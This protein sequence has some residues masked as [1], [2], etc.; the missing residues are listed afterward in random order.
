V[1]WWTPDT[2][3]N[4]IF[5]TPRQIRAQIEACRR[6]L[7]DAVGEHSNLFRPPHGGR[8]PNVLRLVRRLGM[9]P[10]MWSVTGYDWR[11]YSA[12][13]VERRVTSGLR[14]GDVVL[15]HDGGHLDGRSDRA[16]T[17]VATGGL[18][19]RGLDRGYE[20]VTVPQMMAATSESELN[21]TC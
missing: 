2:H 1:P 21:Q 3:P 9:L 15:L 17:V 20:F 12:A 16:A 7:L 18:I 11:G 8:L 5:C 14:G 4:L 10:V 6:V 19:R 13:E